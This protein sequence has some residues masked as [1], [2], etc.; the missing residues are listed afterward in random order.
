MTPRA[1]RAKVR[2]VNN[3]LEAHFGV[4]VWQATSDPLTSLIVTLLSQNT[5]DVNRDR[6]YASLRGR[7]PTWEHVLAAQPEAIAEAIRVG[8]L[9]RQKSVRIKCI[10]QWVKERYGALSLD[11]ICE[12]PN[13]EVFGLLA[14]LPGVGLKTVSVVLAFACGRDVFPVDTH[15]H[16][17]SGRLEFV[18]ANASAEKTHRLMADLVPKG[19]A[20]SFH[21]NLLEFGRAVCKAQRPHCSECFILK[22]CVYYPTLQ[23]RH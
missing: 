7:F 16:R 3:A 11:A 12:M 9:S 2:A 4:P 22:H 18:P 6:A 19:K 1:L 17:I 15:V 20:Y 5:N 10:L 23:I 14:A 13:E 21:L 8:G